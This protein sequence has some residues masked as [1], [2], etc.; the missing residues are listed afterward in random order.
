[1]RIMPII[2]GAAI[3]LLASIPW[4]SAQASAGG[5]T[6][7]VLQASLPPSGETANERLAASPRKAEWAV[8]RAGD[9]SVR[10]WVVYPERREHA[11]VVV[12][13]HDNRGMSNWIRG[14]A[15]Q[16]AADGFIAI[17]PDLLTMLDVPRRA[18][19]ESD[20]DAVREKIRLVDQPTRDRFIQ[21]VG[22]WGTR[23]EGASSKYGVVG[24]CWGGST[25][26]AHAV[27]APASLGAVVV[28]YGG[29]PP[30]ER[31]STV[32]APILGMYGGDDA[33]VNSTVPPAADALTAL[34]RTFETHT[35]AGAGHGFTRSQEGRDGANLAAVKQAWPL[36]V[37]WFRKHLGS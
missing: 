15:D 9:D 21:A 6:L 22:E 33:R 18:D 27:A 12:A 20:G 35:F 1:M 24:F 34:G 29:S 36:T 26:F 2:S 37:A 28:F 13:V 23:L 10:A 11:P 7:L 19:G 17:A 25:V 14:V 32:T 5:G 4:T 8:I 3:L 16:L 31:L 30:P